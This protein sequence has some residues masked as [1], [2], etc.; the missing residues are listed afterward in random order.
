MKR[1]SLMLSTGFAMFS[2]FFGSGN[3][4]FPLLVGKESQGHLF[5]AALGFILTGVL[6]PFL[7]VGAMMLYKGD[8]RAFFGT[9]GR[10]ARF[11]L[12][13]IIL[14]LMGPFGVLARCFTV[15]H[16]SFKLIFPEVE[17]IVFSLVSC[18]LIF[19]ITIN[20]NRIIPMLGQWLTPFLLLA[21]FAIGVFGYWYSDLNVQAQGQWD[22]AFLTGIFKGYQ[23]MDLLAAFVH[24]DRRENL[25][26][27]SCEKMILKSEETDQFERSTFRFGPCAFV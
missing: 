26:E 24:P 22:T 23:T 11:W 15:A 7:G 18:V 25:W 6:V 4:V 12:P 3:L 16:G 8:N 14:G 21:L 5:F 27:H 2:M 10:P 1:Y 17:L 19:M 13:L 20:K 9:L